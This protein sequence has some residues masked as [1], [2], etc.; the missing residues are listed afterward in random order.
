MRWPWPTRTGSS[1]P[2]LPRR[3]PRQILHVGNAARDGFTVGFGASNGATFETQFKQTGVDM[4]MS[5]FALIVLATLLGAIVLA[6]LAVGGG[7][8]GVAIF[9]K[10]KGGDV[11]PAPPSFGGQPG[12]GGYAGGA[13][14]GTGG[15]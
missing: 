2:C 15:Q 1:P 6:I 3:L 8:L 4:P 10:R 14:F 12:A 13:G 11:P 9:E 5:G 7:A